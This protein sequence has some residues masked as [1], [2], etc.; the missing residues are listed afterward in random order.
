MDAELGAVIAGW[1]VA[2]LRSA[3]PL[4]LV[5]LGETLTQ[6]TGLINL[7]VEGQMLAGA[8]VGFAVG[9]TTGDPWLGLAAGA[10][11]GVLLSLV[12]AGLV[13]G[14]RSNQIA[15]GL[16]VW[17][18]GLGATSLLGKGFVG[19]DITPLPPLGSPLTEGLTFV[20][21]FAAQLTAAPLLAIAAVLAAAWWLANTRAGLTWRVVGESAVIAAENGIRAAWIRL[22]AV[23]VGGCLAGL[24]GAVLAIDYTQTWAQEITKG[25]GLIAVGLVIVARWRPM[26]VLPICLVFGIAEVTVLRAQSLGIEVS[27]YLLATLPYA[28]VLV[29]LTISH[30]ISGLRSDMPKDLRGVFA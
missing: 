4:I 18:I 11:A 7:G 12:Y 5:T 29:V 26:L 23:V 14:A 20:G 3:T 15:A 30:A 13:L 17:L 10:L 22:Q 16:A 28:L 24:G 2:A 9:A 21:P 8:C 25:Q 27:S 19:R 1:L 6:R